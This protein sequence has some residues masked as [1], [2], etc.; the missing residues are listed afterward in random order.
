MILVINTSTNSIIYREF[1][2]N[3]FKIDLYPISKHATGFSFKKFSPNIMGLC[4]T[5]HINCKMS[6]RQ[7][8]HVL[9]EV[10]GI[11]ISHRTVA[12]A[13]A[14]IKPFVDTFDYKSSKILSA[15]ETYIKVKVVKHYVWIVMDTCKSLF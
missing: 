2:I 12:N 7:I 13:A 11:K 8:A 9:K 4:L 1:N 3:F 6:T 5:Y 10:H 15:D 14:V